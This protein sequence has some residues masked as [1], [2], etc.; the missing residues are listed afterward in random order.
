M[1]K[2]TLIAVYAVLAFSACFFIWRFKSNY[3]RLMAEGEM[4]ADT[5]L[6]NVKVPDYSRKATPARTDYHL[7]AWG[8]GMVLSVV[9]LRLS[10]AHAVS[11]DLSCGAITVVYNYESG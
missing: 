5:D 1:T 2:R 10:V 9:G 6:I 8:A 11:P 3:S 4:K 7:G